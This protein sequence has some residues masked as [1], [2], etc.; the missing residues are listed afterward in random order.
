[1]AP[2]CAP[3]CRRRGGGWPPPAGRGWSPSPSAPPR[4]AAPAP[5]CPALSGRAT[6]PGRCSFRCGWRPPPPDWWSEGPG[7]GRRTPPRHSSFSGRWQ[8]R[9]AGRTWRPPSP[10]E[11][12]RGDSLFHKPPAHPPDELRADVLEKEVPFPP[13]DQDGE[14]VPCPVV[15]HRSRRAEIPHR[16]DGEGAPVRP[17]DGQGHHGTGGV[18][19][20]RHF[21]VDALGVR[22]SSSAA[23]HGGHL[24]DSDVESLSIW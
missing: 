16:L 10:L 18:K 12:S 7:P 17:S 4:T 19:L 14:A 21:D 1:A 15:A 5:G 20:R 23:F 2:P 3:V 8:N 13:L 6:P 9:C 22:L 24:P 11:I